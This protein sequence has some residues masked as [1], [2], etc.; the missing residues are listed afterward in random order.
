MATVKIGKRGSKENPIISEELLKKPIQIMSASLNDGFCN[1]SYEIST[2]KNVGD[3]HKVKGKNIIHDDLT[4]AFEKF[5]VHL[6]AI[7]EA[8]KN[9]DVKNINALHT[10]ELTMLYH[11]SGFSMKIS[12]DLEQ[13]SLTGTKVVS[14]GSGGRMSLVTPMV[15]LD[16]LSSY[17][18]FNDLLDVA[19]NVRE[20]VE[21]YKDGKCTPVEEEEPKAKQKTI[22]D[23][24]AE[25]NEEMGAEFENAS[26]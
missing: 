7:D 22:G 17:K 12:G 19:N 25:A 26:V 11:V 1:F 18:W 6:A 23:A 13:V 21:L 2:G 5:N 20:E 15:I 9:Q 8:F 3:V 16:D 10:D 14:C 24:I 4:E